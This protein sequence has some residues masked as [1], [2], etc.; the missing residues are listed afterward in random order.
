[1]YSNVH[2]IS[3]GEKI[4]E[5]LMLNVLCDVCAIEERKTKKTEATS[6][7]CRLNKIENIHIHQHKSCECVHCVY[8]LFVYAQNFI[9]KGKLIIFH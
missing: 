9:R 4:N 7:D 8:D 1:M 2:S 3:E 6:T 5:I